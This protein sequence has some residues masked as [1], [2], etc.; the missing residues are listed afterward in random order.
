MGERRTRNKYTDERW[1]LF[2]LENED[3]GNGQL[4]SVIVPVGLSFTANRTMKSKAIR[5]PMSGRVM[6]TETL[7]VLKTQEQYEFKANMM[8]V[9]KVPN[10]NENELATITNAK[11]I[12]KSGRGG[13]RNA[14]VIQEWELTIS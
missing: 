2:R 12:Y 5:N 13:K 10:P 9:A 3:L 8:S 11:P 1:Y 7:E 14:R 4:D 6:D